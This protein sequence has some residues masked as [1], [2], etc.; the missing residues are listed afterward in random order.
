[1]KARILQCRFAIAQYQLDQYIVKICGFVPS[2]LSLLNMANPCRYVA[3][4]F[5]HF[6]G[7]VPQSAFLAACRACGVY[8]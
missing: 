5:A 8:F 7:A 3:P 4:D 6:A 1:M 2:Q